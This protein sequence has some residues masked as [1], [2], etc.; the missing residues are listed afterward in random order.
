MPFLDYE[1]PP[2]LIAQHPAQQR[3]QSRLMVLNRAKQIIGH[4]QFAELPE[5]LR[6]GDLLILNNTRVLPARLFGRRAQTGGQWEG[7]FLEEADGIWELACQ[8]RGTL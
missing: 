8:T 3:D 4:N 1:L 6:P 5:L 2:H 7:L